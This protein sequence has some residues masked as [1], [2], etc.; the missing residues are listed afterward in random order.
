LAAWQGS[1]L[2]KELDDDEKADVRA[3]YDYFRDMSA[4]AKDDFAAWDASAK[5]HFEYTKGKFADEANLLGMTRREAEEMADAIKEQHDANRKM[6]EYA[7]ESA[8][9]IAALADS[10]GDL[11][12]S[13]QQD[14]MVATIVRQFEAAREAGNS[15]AAQYIANLL[16][17]SKQLQLAFEQSAV[18]TSSGYQ[19]LSEMT[20]QSAGDFSEVLKS[21]AE[22]AAKRE[23]ATA[24]SPVVNFNGGQTF[25]INQDFRDADPDRV[26]YVMQRD[27]LAAAS[28]RLQ[29]GYATPFGT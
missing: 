23:K 2:L 10:Q 20:Q 27:V 16:S 22:S 26:F 18:M 24:K 9:R 1:K 11:D 6:V 14:E 21:L 25:K 7:E 19:M 12:R 28:R 15:G 5:S 17:N 8:Q 3:R 4:R 13:D 29:S